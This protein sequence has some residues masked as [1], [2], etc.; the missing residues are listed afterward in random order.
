M[1]NIENIETLHIELTN[2]CNAAC[3]ACARTIKEFNFNTKTDKA[4]ITLEQFKNLFD[5]KLLEKI[6]KIIFCGVYGD[7]I[8]A[9]DLLEIIGYVKN[10]NPTISLSVNTNGGLRSTNWWATFGKLMSDIKDC[11]VFSIDG[12]EDTNHIYRVNT[13]FKKIIEN[14][15]AFISAGGRAHWD[16]LIFD[17]NEHQVEQCEALA[18]ELGFKWF[19]RKVST[20]NNIDIYNNAFDHRPSIYNTIEKNKK[21]NISCMALNDKSVYIT[22][23]GTLLPCCIIGEKNYLSSFSISHQHLLPKDQLNLNK[24]NI[25][26]VIP[27]LNQVVETWST[28]NPL[29]VCKEACNFD[30]RMDLLNR[31]WI[32]E[33]E[34]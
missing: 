25:K 13:N 24:T 28:N 17:Y 33:I 30:A 15:K 9:K 8:V 27:I 2:Q 5:V 22:A 26:K 3:P 14:A 12:L 18:R 10:I 20:R 19:R 4:E 21:I 16:M 29:D 1:F 6:N 7:P 11:V 34:F 23:H 31:M 32:K